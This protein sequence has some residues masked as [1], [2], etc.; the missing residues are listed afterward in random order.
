MSDPRAELVAE[1]D[2]LQA[3][4]ESAT[5]GPWVV[6]V[7]PFYIIAPD[8]NHD[9]TTDQ[10]IRGEDK[11]HIVAHDPA[12]TLRRIAGVREVVEEHYA[13]GAI[14]PVCPGEDSREQPGCPHR[15]RW[16]RLCDPQDSTWPCTTI[17]A[18]H[19][20]FCGSTDG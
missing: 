14:C 12:S 7:S 5:P 3:L 10:F 11:H 20:A 18:L 15:P 19:A 2:R 13:T 4:A 8:V 1:L 16:C 9:V 6:E 17:L